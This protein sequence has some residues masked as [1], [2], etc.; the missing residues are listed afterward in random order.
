LQEEHGS[1]T[2]LGVSII[3]A[4]HQIVDE[5]P[6]I[7]EDPISPLLLDESQIQT[8]RSEPQRHNS[9]AARG[10]RSHIVLRSRFAEDEL[11]KA[12]NHGVKQF[13]NLG[14][15]YDTYPY[16]Q[17]PWASKLRM[18]EIDHPATQEAKR[19]HFRAKGLRD[20]ENI[21]F[22]PFDLEKKDLAEGLASTQLDRQQIVWTTCLGVLAYL[23]KQTV[24]GIFM[25]VAAMPK[26]S[27]ITFAFASE[28]AAS[29]GAGEGA[30]ASER[31]AK[32]GEPWISLF[33][34]QD[35]KAELSE[36]GFSEIS[37]LQPGEATKK[38]YE[39]R[40]DLPAPRTTRLC[41]AKV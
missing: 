8:I 22:L 28:R 3:R 7:L 10:L 36:C 5:L 16:R 18:V 4:V 27:G 6:H 12:A 32:L 39:N 20:P 1:N 41:S 40:T 30:F 25:T 13:V 33:T 17:P 31:A 23:R 14:A 37:F 2:A 21:E 29:N 34:V 9:R 38:Y 26:G 15:G 19:A 24:H 35:L 11:H